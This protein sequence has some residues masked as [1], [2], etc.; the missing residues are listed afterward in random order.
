MQ[1]SKHVCTQHPCISGSQV[2]VPPCHKDLLKDEYRR[3]RRSHSRYY[4]WPPL[5]SSGVPICKTLSKSK[6]SSDSAPSAASELL[7]AADSSFGSSAPAASPVA[8][9]TS[10]GVACCTCSAMRPMHSPVAV[11]VS[12]RLCC[13]RGWIYNPQHTA[14]RA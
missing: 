8:A 1:A 12:Q 14:V 3:L 4:T 11:L 2:R 7:A 6:A 9:C 5:A 13:S 10:A